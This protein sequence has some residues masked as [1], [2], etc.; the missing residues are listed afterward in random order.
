MKPVTAV[1][2]TNVILSAL[3]WEGNE[4]KIMGLAEEGKIKLFT[5]VALLDELRKV[6]M[7]ERF[8][9]DEKTVDDNVKYIL[10]ISEIIPSKH[11]IRVIRKTRTMTGCWNAHWRERRDISFPG[12]SIYCN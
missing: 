7:Y 3:F 5:S 8:G 2:D 9:L 1:A 12:T 10:T 4:S 6:L 11:R